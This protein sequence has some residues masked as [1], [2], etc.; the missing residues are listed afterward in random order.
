MTLFWP[1]TATGYRVESTLSFTATS[2]WSTVIG[3]FQTNGGFISLPSLP[4]TG[5]QKFFRLIKP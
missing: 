5:P 4:T 2:T 1:D 3:T